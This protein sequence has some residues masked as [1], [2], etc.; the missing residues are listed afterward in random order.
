MLG[1]RHWALGTRY[2]PRNF[3][4]SACGVMIRTSRC[5]FTGEQVP[6]IARDERMHTCL[7][8][9]SKNH[10]VD[11]V[12]RHRLGWSLRRGTSSTARSTTSRLDWAARRR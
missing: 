2:P 10:V 11:W 3:I 8:R 7:N 4:S 5:S 1:P 9:T 6:A 12:A